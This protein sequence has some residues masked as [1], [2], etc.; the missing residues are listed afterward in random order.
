MDVAWGFARKWTIRPVED[1]VF[2]LQVLCLGD[3][4]RALL[5]G[6]SIFRQQGVLLEPYDGIADPKLVILDRM[7]AWV[8]I[9]GIPPLFQKERIVKD[10]AANW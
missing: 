8:Q 4:N 6:P 5:E 1:N 2:I 3:W 9:R 10:M 7:H